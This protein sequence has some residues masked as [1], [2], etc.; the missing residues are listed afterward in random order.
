MSDIWLV[1][2]WQTDEQWGE[3]VEVAE[4]ISFPNLD[5]SSMCAMDGM[6]HLACDKQLK[7]IA[8]SLRAFEGAGIGFEFAVGAGLMQ[9]YCRR[10]G[11]ITDLLEWS[12]PSDRFVQ[13]TSIAPRG[14]RASLAQ[15]CCPRSGGGCNPLCL[16]SIGVVGSTAGPAASWSLVST[17]PML[18]KGIRPSISGSAWE[19]ARV[20]RQRPSCRA[21]GLVQRRSRL[22]AHRLAA[23]WARSSRRIVR[24]CNQTPSQ[25]GSRRE[26]GCRPVWSTVR[27]M[28]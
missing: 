26:G 27:G 19:D 17:H 6:A 23:S 16:V 15:P 13:A 9:V 4:F 8:R 14:M 20:D 10:W 7:S 5:A 28:G 22:S 2:S 24:G 21:T 18:P 1:E 12:D 3:G 11:T 25:T